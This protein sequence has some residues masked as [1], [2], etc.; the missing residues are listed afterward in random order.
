MTIN[1]KSRRGREVLLR[2]VAQADVLVE[3]FRPGLLNRLG[4]GQQCMQLLVDLK[5]TARRER[6]STMPRRSSWPTTERPGPASPGSVIASSPTTTAPHGE[7]SPAKTPVSRSPSLINLASEGRARGDVSGDPSAVGCSTRTTGAGLP[8]IANGG[9]EDP[10]TARS[11]LRS[12]SADVRSAKLRSLNTIGRVEHAMAVTS[13]VTRTLRPLRRWPTSRTGTDALTCRWS[14]SRRR[15]TAWTA[16]P[17]A[18]VRRGSAGGL[19][20][21]CRSSAVARGRSGACRDDY[22]DLELPGVIGR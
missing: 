20:G 15:C 1:L 3:N 6:I 22:G 2:S 18:A 17:V 5:Q 8:V 12:G 19:R 14:G 21:E 7:N 4:A 9:L 11:L 16:G 10:E 13:P